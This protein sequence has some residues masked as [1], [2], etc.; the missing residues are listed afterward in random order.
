[1][2]NNDIFYY[3]LIQLIDYIYHHNLLI[4]VW[5]FMTGFTLF[6]IY[7][8]YNDDHV[9]TLYALHNTA[10]HMRLHN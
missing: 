10:A 1:M 3:V 7:I 5:V 9:V 4:L 2:Y 8:L 6:C